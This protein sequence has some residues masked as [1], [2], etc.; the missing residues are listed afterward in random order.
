M[1]LQDAG[2]RYRTRFKIVGGIRFYGRLFEVPDTTR[3]T[4]FHSARRILQVRPQTPVKVG[5]VILTPTQQRYIVAEHGE[6][7]RERHVYSEFKLFEAENTGSWTREQTA[8]DTVTGLQNKSSI[9]DL[10]T[11]YFGLQPAGTVTGKLQI[12]DSK[13]DLITHAALEPGDQVDDYVVQRVVKQLGI[14]I[15]EVR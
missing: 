3:V 8:E 10:G 5:D 9:V 14:Y 6:G 4:N 13:F 1:R 15:A 7:F 11:I 12:P 2:A